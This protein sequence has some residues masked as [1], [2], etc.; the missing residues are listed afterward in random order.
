MIS[1]ARP[2][3]RDLASLPKA[4]LHLHL[5]GA[6]RPRTLRDLCR[7]HSIPAPSIPCYDSSDIPLPRSSTPRFSDF[8][9]FADVYVAA[10]ACLRTEEDLRRLVLKVALDLRACNVLYAEVAPSLTYY[11]KHFGSTGDAALRVLVDAA[12]IARPR[13]AS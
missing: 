10:C 3:P 8:S 7:K 13:P 4:E 1:G 2:K 11:Y 9:A 5:E 6:M 12:A